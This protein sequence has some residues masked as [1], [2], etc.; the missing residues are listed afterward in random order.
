MSF[1]RFESHRGPQ[2]MGEINMTPLI[3]VMLVLLVIFIITAPLLMGAVKVNLP[4]ASAASDTPSPPSVVSIVI[5]ASGHVFVADQP[6]TLEVLA[7]TLRTTAQAHP[8][9]EV[10]LRADTSVA[11]GR[12]VEVMGLAQQAGLTRIGFVFLK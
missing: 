3:D 2:P 7:S 5:D 8:N 4:K 9:T 10:Q 11:Y 6:Q 1:G 12:V